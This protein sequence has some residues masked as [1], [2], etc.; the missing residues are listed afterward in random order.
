MLITIF[1]IHEQHTQ[2]KSRHCAE[3][4][5]Q[6]VKSMMT[7]AGR[8]KLLQNIKD[9]YKTATVA[10]AIVTNMKDRTNLNKRT[11]KNNRNMQN[12][13]GTRKLNDEYDDSYQ[14]HTSRTQNNSEQLVRPVAAQFPSILRK[15]QTWKRKH[16]NTKL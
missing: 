10:V 16:P 11:H 3:K 1:G 5:V 4:T 9:S 7:K 14:S 8:N 6:V 13:P 2:R 12:Y 15:D